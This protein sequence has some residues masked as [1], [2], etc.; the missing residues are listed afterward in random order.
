M[1]SPFLHLRD[2]CFFRYDQ[3][4]RLG[5][6]GKRAIL[7]LSNG[8]EYELSCPKLIIQ[9]AIRNYEAARS[10]APAPSPKWTPLIHLP[11]GTSFHYE[12][13]LC[14]IGDRTHTRTWSAEDSIVTHYQHPIDSP[15]QKHVMDHEHK[16]YQIERRW[17]DAER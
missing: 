11:T 12:S 15:L 17:Y 7:T 14:A 13:L 8:K 4:R 9:E 10:E 16:Y 3:I 5:G 1:I 6:H 2:G